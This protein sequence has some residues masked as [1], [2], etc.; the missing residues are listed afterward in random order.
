MPRLLLITDSFP[1]AFAPRMG[2]LCKFLPKLGWDIDVITEQNDHY[3]H[4]YIDL[5]FQRVTVRQVKYYQTNSK[6]EYLFKYILNIIYPHKDYFFYKKTKADIAQG[7]YDCVLCAAYH[8][9]PLKF[10]QLAA[11]KLAVPLYTDLRDIMEQYAQPHGIERLCWSLKG[12]GVHKKRRNRILQQSTAVSTV[13]NWHVK[14]LSEYNPNTHLI[15]N[16]YDAELFQSKNIVS[17]KF[18]IVYTGSLLCLKDQDPSLFFE[19]MDHLQNK[20]AFENIHVDWFVDE[21]SEQVIKQSSEKYK[22]NEICKFHGLKNS[23]EVPNILHG[24]SVVLVIINTTSA[25]GPHGGMTTKFFEALGVE[26]PVL[27]VPSDEADLANA[28]AQTNAG[29]AARTVEEIEQFILEKYAEWQQNGFT[30]QAVNQAQKA[31]FTR[32]K[33]AEQFSKM[34]INPTKV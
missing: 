14:T 4:C 33:Q 25:D 22:S 2:N 34:M 24:S 1:P 12:W 9:F 6:L 31:Q 13:S 7:Q 32:Q 19:A 17:D 5:D 27:C 20:I 18:H 16:G 23:K 26:K 3:K 28:M 11:T 21:K 10:A 8:I 30:R 29:V 15:F